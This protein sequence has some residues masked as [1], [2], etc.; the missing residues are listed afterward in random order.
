V[1]NF[2]NEKQY[3]EMTMKKSYTKNIENENL[4]NI[5]DRHYI[6]D[7]ID[8][9]NS[10]FRNHFED[11]VK[12]ESLIEHPFYIA[13]DGGKFSRLLSYALSLETGGKVI[14][15]YLRELDGELNVLIGTKDGLKIDEVCEAELHRLA[16]DAEFS[17]TLRDDAII[18][19]KKVEFVDT[20]PIHAI[21]V[22]NAL[23]DQL[24]CAFFGDKKN[25]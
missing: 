8:T 3:T 4:V 17:I 25:V 13:F 10:F 9:L 1:Q 6:Y 18:A 16:E 23:Y 24:Y 19:S 7:L 11:V 22:Q 20:V 5:S 21:N 15:I 14:H 12:I 2:Q